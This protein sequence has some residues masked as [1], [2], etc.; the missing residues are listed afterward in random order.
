M[1]YKKYYE[2][3]YTWHFVNSHYCYSECE[4]FKTE[5]EA[6]KFVLDLLHRTDISIVEC[7]KKRVEKWEN[8]LDK[9]YKMCYN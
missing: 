8:T 2:V 6:N 1:E 7:E 4:I 5:L 9:V 3:N